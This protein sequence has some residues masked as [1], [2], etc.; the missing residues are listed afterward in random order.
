MISEMKKTILLAA[1]IL[2]VFAVDMTESYSENKIE[3]LPLSYRQWLAEDA[4]YLIT[5]REK[6]IFLQ[7]GSNPERDLFI[8]A[9]WKQR[10]PTP[11]TPQNEFKEEHYRRIDH[12]NKT[13]GRGTSKSGWRTDRGRIYIILGKPVTTES[14]GALEH[15]L[16]PMEV[17]FYQGE[18]GPGIPTSF[19][20]V[21]FKEWGI[22]EYTLYSPAR[23]GPRK[24]LETYDVNP[25]KALSILRQVNPELANVS[26]SLIP[27]QSS[28]LGSQAAIASE[29]LLNNV[30]ILPKKKVKD[31]YAEKLLKY[32]SIIEVDHSVLYI[33][34][35]SIVKVIAD[36]AGF[37][38][39][40]YA[41]EPGKLSIGQFEDKYY[42]NLEVFGKVSGLDGT[43]IH[44]FE[45]EIS[46]NFD[47]DQVAE[48]RAKL[49]SLQG[50]FPMIPGSY[51][52]SILI[53]N[54]VSKE[55]TSTE[56]DITVPQNT[57]ELRMSPLVLS[58]KAEKKSSSAGLRRPFQ[59]GDL[60]VY[61]PANKSFSPKDR[62]HVYFS[63]TG[64]SADLKEKGM[65][66]VS[67]IR[68]GERMQVSRKKMGEYAKADGYLESFPLSDFNP[69]NYTLRVSL[70]D[71]NLDEVLA[72]SEDFVITPVASLPRYWSVSEVH[73]GTN[74]PHY[75]FVLGSQMLN[76]GEYGKAR[77]LLE[78]AYSRSPGS[79][80]YALELCR[81][82]FAGKDFSKAQE[83]LTRFLEKAKEESG[84]YHMLGD[85][86]FFLEEYGRAVYYYKKYLMNFGTH[87]EILNSLGE[88]HFRT[89][90][91]EEALAVW[92][93][94]LELDPNQQ[95]VRNRVTD[96]KK[97]Q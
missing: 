80:E 68:N 22:G 31:D 19:Y 66:D 6:E 54:S 53:K 60:F 75:P 59:F 69:G 41:V 90:N 73:P 86:S 56:Q 55:F 82:Y 50:V 52:M 81:A 40:H 97:K 21:F 61:P 15:N 94:S 74:D 43:T 42:T 38:F 26:R 76:A 88:C 45:R 71:E 24:L 14:Y 48:M 1:V 83:V 72:E 17:W 8:E 11:G 4:V 39:I 32:R 2:T 79:L 35:D 28:T 20:M 36:E 84:I 64:L 7:L 58:F 33:E 25:N 3:D 47:R 51:K 27:G 37:F 18:F 93:K 57:A 34:N 49:F 29:M 12:A 89:G 85:A 5:D 96:L 87:L 63:I 91:T 16:V 46:L 65:I 77:E 10:D 30:S 67:A 13:F 78:M 23:H 95:K 9:F 62:M 70:M 92:E 44:Q